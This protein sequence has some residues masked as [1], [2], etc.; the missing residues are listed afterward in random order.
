VLDNSEFTSAFS[1]LV[2]SGRLYLLEALQRQGQALTVA[3]PPK[4]I[5]VPTNAD[6]TTWTRSTRIDHANIL[7]INQSYLLTLLRETT[8]REKAELIAAS[9]AQEFRDQLPTPNVFLR[10]AGL[11]IVWDMWDL[12][13][14]DPT[15][16]LLGEFVVAPAWWCMQTLTSLNAVR[17]ELAGRVANEVLMVLTSGTYQKRYSMPL[18]CGAKTSQVSGA[19]SLKKLSLEERGEYLNWGPASG[20]AVGPSWFGPLPTHVL[21]VVARCENLAL[22]TAKPLLDVILAMELQ[23]IRISGP[24]WA[25]ERLVPEWA[26]TTNGTLSLPLRRF[27]IPDEMD[28]DLEPIRLTAGRIAA[29]GIDDPQDRMD[30]ALQRYRLSCGRE[31]DADA[32]LDLVIAL[33]AL[34]L[35]GEFQSSGFQ[36]ALNGTHW[37]IGPHR[38]KENVFDGL[39]QIYRLRN[40]LVHGEGVVSYADLQRSRN[41]AHE[42]ASAGLLRAVNGFVPDQAY[43]KRALLA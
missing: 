11:Q 16:Q 17:E 10:A 31:N 41:L 7:T 19:I 39:R 12:E 5:A 37:I 24:G 33:E 20:S 25:K 9:L 40:R 3:T 32:L 34:L 21:D 36:L 23:G 43:F 30:R 2:E 42:L 28:V 14:H 38:S 1:E 8:W 26:A 13:N 15:P 6:G 35:P 22:M 4:I 27:Q 18:T 29:H